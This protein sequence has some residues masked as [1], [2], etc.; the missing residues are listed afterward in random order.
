MYTN[1]KAKNICFV[2]G[3]MSKVEQTYKSIASDPFYVDVLS[4]LYEHD[5]CHMTD[6]HE[7]INFYKTIVKIVDHLESL[8]IV[9]KNVVLE[10][11]LSFDIRLTPKGHELAKLAYDFRLAFQEF[12]NVK[13]CCR[14]GTCSIPEC[15]VSPPLCASMRHPRI[16]PSIAHRTRST[17]S[18]PSASPRC[19]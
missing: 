17:I 8:G 13:S 1:D 5:G 9:T 6:L 7:V 18:D 4:Y 12:A 15:P 3:C 10:P 16:H 14:T 19:I 11:R 2:F